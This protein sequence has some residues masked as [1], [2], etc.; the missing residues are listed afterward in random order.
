MASVSMNIGLE[1]SLCEA[2]KVKPRIHGDPEMLE[3]LVLW[4]TQHKELLSRKGACQGDDRNV[5]Q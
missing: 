4:H 5:L 1:R 2:V 3:M